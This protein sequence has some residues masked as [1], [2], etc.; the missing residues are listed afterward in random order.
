MSA[1]A[2]R[3]AALTGAGH[4]DP[5]R[6]VEDGVLLDVQ[7][8]TVRFGGVVANNEVNLSAREGS[9]TALLGPNGAGKTTLF[10]VVSGEQRASSGRVVF[11][12]KD[13]TTA[14]R[15]TR[16]RLG[17]GRTFQNLAVVSE[18]SVLDNVRV[19]AASFGTY[20]VGIALLG[21]PSVRRSDRYTKSLAMQ[22]LH[23]VGMERQASML[24]SALPY[25]DLRRLELARAL[26]LNP[27]LL[28]LDEPAAGLD[29]QESQELV[30]AL[31]M[32]RDH[33]N[34]TIML[35]EH[36]LELVRSLA[37]D[38][39]VLDFGKILSGGPVTDVLNDPIVIEAYVGKPSKHITSEIENAEV[40]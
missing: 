39:Y 35:V 30:G 37:E 6:P 17:M 33:W 25:G 16:A 7:D 12:G 22:A 5:A 29:N 19:G 9:I 15:H 38:A 21:L 11:A 32:I 24:A 3:L 1:L 14:P 2:E 36:D 13:I 8:V 28:L 27:R 4:G 40:A 26:C 34:I 18:L 20:G 23:A 31:R 10:N